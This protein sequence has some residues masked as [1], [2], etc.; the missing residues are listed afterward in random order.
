MEEVV[1]FVVTRPRPGPPYDAC[2]PEGPPPKYNISTSNPELADIEIEMDRRP[3]GCGGHAT[4]EAK[5]S[6][7]SNCFINCEVMLWKNNSEDQIFKLFNDGG[8][9]TTKLNQECS[10]FLKSHINDELSMQLRGSNRLCRGKLEIKFANEARFHWKTTFEK[11]KYPL[12][13]Q[14]T[15]KNLRYVGK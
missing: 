11:D 3:G 13:N 12:T 5:I 8:T 15:I 1:D 7:K 4:I 9:I 10:V 2:T 14:T 6:L